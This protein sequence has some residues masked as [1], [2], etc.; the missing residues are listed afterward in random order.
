MTP[1]QCLRKQ[2]ECEECIVFSAHSA[3]ERERY[4][5]LN[6]T[7]MCSYFTTPLHKNRIDLIMCS[8]VRSGMPW[9]EDTQCEKYWG[10]HDTH[11]PLTRIPFNSDKLRSLVWENRVCR[12]WQST[13]SKLA[14]SK[15]IFFLIR[16]KNYLCPFKLFLLS[17]ERSFFLSDSF[18]IKNSFIINL[19]LLW[20]NAFFSV[21]KDVN[22][23]RAFESRYL[24]DVLIV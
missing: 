19:C 8:A 1:S 18:W 20:N 2:V 7:R 24:D 12:E 23:S 5:Q 13:T 11:I 6:S 14:I 3:C 21:T 10:E 17:L 22:L 15:L 4:V 9:F 16:F